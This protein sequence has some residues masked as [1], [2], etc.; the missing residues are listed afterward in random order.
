MNCRPPRQFLVQE[1]YLKYKNYIE[2]ILK[3]EGMKIAEI[4]TTILRW[5][6]YCGYRRT[7]TREKQ[8]TSTRML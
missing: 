5:G 3:N 4:A 6:K 2:Q 7:A 8:C 1:Y